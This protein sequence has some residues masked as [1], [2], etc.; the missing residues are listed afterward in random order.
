MVFVGLSKQSQPDNKD[1]TTASSSIGQYIAKTPLSPT[2]GSEAPE[3][4]TNTA[5]Q[6][7]FVIASQGPSRE[8]ISQSSSSSAP[9]TPT[10]RTTQN[11]ELIQ[12]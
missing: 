12:R 6:Y 5:S 2:A 10:L 8:A 9:L 3:L 4:P 7:N 1:N 11:L